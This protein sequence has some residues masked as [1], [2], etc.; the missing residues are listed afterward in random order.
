MKHKVTVQ[1]LVTFLVCLDVVEF[2]KGGMR[3]GLESSWKCISLYGVRFSLEP[4][5]PRWMHFYIDNV[6]ILVEL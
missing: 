4:L 5:H 1:Q 3:G 6:E 2:G